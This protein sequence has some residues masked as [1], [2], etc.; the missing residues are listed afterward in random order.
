MRKSII[1]DIKY[2]VFSLSSLI[3]IIFSFALFSKEIIMAINDG[4]FSGYRYPYVSLVDGSFNYTAFMVFAPILA[5]SVASMNLCHDLQSG[6]IKNI[7]FKQDKKSYAG[8]RFIVCTLSGGLVMSIITAILMV[9]I[10]IVGRPVYQ[11]DALDSGTFNSTAFESIQFIGGGTFLAFVV[12]I[13]SFIFGG[14]WAA[15]GLTFSVYKPNKYLAVAFPLLLYYAI[16]FTFGKFEILDKFRP[17]H[18]LVP[19]TAL[20][21][22]IGFILAEQLIFYLLVLC[23]YS[24]GIQWRLKNV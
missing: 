18:M 16:N 2:N 8:S 7:L 5:S 4:S 11:P 17:M 10:L 19:G 9:I 23:I 13:L 14:L 20:V 6:Y 15:V 1:M 24:I 12:I 3:G 22:S 21:P